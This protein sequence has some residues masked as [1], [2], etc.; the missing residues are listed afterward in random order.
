M[1][2]VQGVL[3]EE[4]TAFCLTLE[5]PWLDNHQD[6]SC[7]PSGLYVCHRTNSPRHGETFEVKDVQNRTNILFHRGNFKDDSVGCILCGEQFEYWN[8]KPMIK[9][10]AKAFIEFMSILKGLDS[11][12]LNILWC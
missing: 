7:I 12:Q 1:D 9:Y 11:F 8:N 10:S 2:G 3:I 5:R 6:I 4:T